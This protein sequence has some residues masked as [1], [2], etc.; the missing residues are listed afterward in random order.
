MLSGKFLK[1]VVKPKAVIEPKGGV[2]KNGTLRNF[3]GTAEP[4]Q[5]KIL[6]GNL[7]RRLHAVQARGEITRSSE[8]KGA[9]ENGGAGKPERFGDPVSLA[10]QRRTDPVPPIRGKDADRRERQ[11]G[12][13]AD[14]RLGE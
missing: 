12:L 7:F 6:V 3:S 2:V 8:E 11:L 9:S 1:T 5:H 4:I 10:D 14:V 13:S